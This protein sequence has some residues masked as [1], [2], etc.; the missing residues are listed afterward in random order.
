M[1]EDISPFAATASAMGYLYQLRIA[2]LRCTDLLESGASWT[3]AIEAGD[4]IECVQDEKTGLW[5]LKHRAEGTRITD[6]TSDLWKSLRVWAVAARAGAID[7][8]TADLFLLTTAEA[9]P[10]SAAMHLSQAPGDRRDP[11]EAHRLLREARNAARSRQQKKAEANPDTTAK[12]SELY[13][14]WDALGEPEQLRLLERIQIL[15]RAEDIHATGTRLQGRAAIAVGR[16]FATSFLERLEG[17]FFQRVIAQMGTSA[18]PVTGIEFDEAFSSRRDQFRPDNLPIDDD[19]IKLPDESHL[20]SDKTFVRQ[21]S[22]TGIGSAR[23][24]IAV[25]DWLRASTQRDRWSNENLLRPGEIDIYER[26]L[27]EEW[28][29][30][31]EAMRDDLGEQVAEEAMTAA[32]KALYRWVEQEARYSI[33]PGCEE[34]F[35]TTGSFHMLADGL[36]VGWHPQYAA[37]LMTLLE[38]AGSRS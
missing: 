10:A 11:A 30:R 29:V 14:A 13:Q 32:A 36:D 8:D 27:T 21:L 1:A 20:H 28:E 26:R 5:Q 17:W 9:P 34:P 23:V 38:P 4:D 25:R 24:R 35:V 37:R 33:R 16:Q 7:L 15:H 3:V 18:G 12:P 19:V 6:G 31:F 2:L 22:L